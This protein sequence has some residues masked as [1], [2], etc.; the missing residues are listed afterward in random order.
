MTLWLYNRRLYLWA[1][2]IFAGLLFGSIIHFFKDWLNAEK[3]SLALS[4]LI[5]LW[6]LSVFSFYLAVVAHTLHGKRSDKTSKI[7]K[8]VCIAFFSTITLSGTLI[9][10]FIFYSIVLGN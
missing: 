1:I 4:L 8:G 5:F 10:F 2:G 9:A 7:M 6:L 3:S